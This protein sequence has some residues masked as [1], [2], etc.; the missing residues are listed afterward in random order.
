MLDID[1]PTGDKLSRLSKAGDIA[2]KFTP[3]VISLASVTV[4]Y[5]GFMA[6]RNNNRS[7]NRPILTFRVTS[8][9]VSNT[10]VK[11]AKS[12]ETRQVRTNLSIIGTILNEGKTGAIV[13][14]LS[15]SL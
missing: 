2:L 14:K 8:A 4:S 6:T 15:F 9:G 12:S 10:F 1:I 3:I 11:M 5:V 7:V 13:E